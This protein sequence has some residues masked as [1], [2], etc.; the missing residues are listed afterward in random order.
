M[1][2]NVQKDSI[3]DPLL[4]GFYS[5]SEAACLV[6]IR[7]TVIRGWLNGY[8]NSRLDSIIKRDFIGTRT[9]SF[10]D[11]MELRF[12]KYFLAHKVSIHTIRKAVEKARSEWEIKHPLAMFGNK[13]ITDRRTIFAQVAEEDNDKVT[14]NMASGQHELWEVIERTIAKGVIFDPSEHYAKAWK[15]RPGD[16]DNVIIDPGIAFGRAVVEGTRV[17]TSALFQLWKAEKDTNCVAGWFNVSPSDVTTAIDYE[18]AI[19]A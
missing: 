4:A 6:Q 15:P 2:I 1:R 8:P 16:F 12:I 19:A 3:V 10:L 17:P 5:T 18:V 14:W 9:I 13:F 11:L 7:P